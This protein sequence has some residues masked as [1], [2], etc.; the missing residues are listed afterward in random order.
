MKQ[1]EYEH[2]EG[3]G[4]GLVYTDGS[5]KKAGGIG[6]AGWGTWS[7]DPGLVACGP[8][9]G[10]DQS[11]ARA[12]VRAIVAAAEIARGR[13]RVISD[14]KYVAQIANRV[15]QGGVC[16]EGRHEDLWKRF[17]EHR[18]GRKCHLD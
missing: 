7:E 15:I 17:F 18:K 4:A 5:A 11:A 14:N 9:G 6:Y 2:V 3:D 13:I 12:E 10:Y 8:A 1:G 16:P